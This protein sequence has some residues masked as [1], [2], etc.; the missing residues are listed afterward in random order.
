M[1]DE[2]P[3][4]KP[5][6]SVVILGTGRMAP[7]IATA[8]ALAGAQVYVVGRNLERAQD[9]AKRASSPVV[10]ARSFEPAAFVDASLVVETIV[11]DARVKRDV[12]AMIEPWLADDTLIVSNT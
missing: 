2:R 10:Q 12:I 5:I 7:G 6:E 1:L 9:A 4:G 11:E 3:A 8:C